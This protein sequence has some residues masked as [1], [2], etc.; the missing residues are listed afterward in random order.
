MGASGGEPRPRGSALPAMC[1]HAR[2]PRARAGRNRS[3]LNGT[4]LALCAGLVFTAAAPCL[5]AQ[6]PLPACAYRVRNQQTIA[7]ARGLLRDDAFADAYTVYLRDLDASQQELDG[8]VRDADEYARGR[9]RAYSEAAAQYE[10]DVG[11][12]NASVCVVGPLAPEQLA[13]CRYRKEQLDL[14]RGS[15]LQRREDD[16][17]LEQDLD[18]RGRELE[19]RAAGVLERAALVLDP[20]HVEDALR[21]YISWLQRNST[22]GACSDLA[23]IAERLGLRVQNQWLFLELLARNL[24]PHPD[25]LRWLIRAT[26]L[27][28]FAFGASGFKARFRTNL[29]DN[30]VRHALAYMVVGYKYEGAGADLVSQVRDE[31]RGQPQDYWLAVEAG[32]MGFQL[33]TGTYD[34]GNFGRAIRGRLCE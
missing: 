9:C 4:A 19:A 26:E 2:L 29:T 10:A 25:R 15:L 5:V 6:P 11:A 16:Q 20:D 12:F 34:T 3:S 24:V 31:L 14:R 23:R 22:G 27:T 1:G 33:R 30:Q 18:R 13:D 32:H 8:W 21:L 17:A 7:Q 28:P